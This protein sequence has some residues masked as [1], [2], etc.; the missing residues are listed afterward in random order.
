MAATLALVITVSAQA[1][2]YLAQ[3]GASPSPLP[4]TPGERQHYV[5][6]H[7]D[8]KGKF[9]PPHY[10][11]TKTLH[12]RGYYAADAQA[13]LNQKQHGYKEPTPV[14]SMPEAPPIDKPVE[15]R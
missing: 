3:P 2:D 9:V 14:Y 10:E 8:T 11:A 4:T 13:R 7:F 1:Q 6:G 15:G 12:F 5:A